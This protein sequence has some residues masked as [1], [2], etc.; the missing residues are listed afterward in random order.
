VKHVP[1]KSRHLANSAVRFGLGQDNDSGME[2]IGKRDHV[3]GPCEISCNFI[4]LAFEELS[5]N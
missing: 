4:W 3:W 5:F 1:A 2:R